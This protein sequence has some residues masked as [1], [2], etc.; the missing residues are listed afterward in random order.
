MGLC[1]GCHQFS[2]HCDHIPSRVNQ[3]GSTNCNNV[4]RGSFCDQPPRPYT[5]TPRPYTHP[6]KPYTHPPK[7]Y[8]ISYQSPRFHTQ[9][10][11][12]LYYPQG[13]NL[14]N[15]NG[16]ISS[17]TIPVNYNYNAYRV[18]DRTPYQK[19]QQANY[20]VL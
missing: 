19:Q 18:Q 13:Q 17:Q 6:P 7:P 3:C 1:L 8:N 5:H 9:P 2:D 11:F 10:Q 4:N 12:K 14:R 16:T 15:P 20:G